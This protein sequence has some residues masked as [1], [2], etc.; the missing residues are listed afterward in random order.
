MARSAAK[1]SELAPRGH[2]PWRWWRAEA[3]DAEATDPTCRFPSR[4]SCSGLA[5][6]AAWRLGQDG[7]QHGLRRMV[8]VSA[9]ENRPIDY[10]S[11]RL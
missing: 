3:N 2:F 8:R 11:D 6:V 5:Q 4:R 1:S 9:V 10:S 7:P